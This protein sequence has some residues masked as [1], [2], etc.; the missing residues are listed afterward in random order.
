[1]KKLNDKRR[2]SDNLINYYNGT[3]EFCSNSCIVF[4]PDHSK[5][6]P[7]G[8]GSMCSV[9]SS[10]YDD[11]DVKPHVGQYVIILVN[12]EGRELDNPHYNPIY[13]AANYAEKMGLEDDI[14][15]EK[16]L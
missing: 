15:S 6:V 12:Y 10:Y 13:D 3:I 11:T 14:S 8:E 1:M 9:P 5:P 16:R 7:W 4:K 2:I